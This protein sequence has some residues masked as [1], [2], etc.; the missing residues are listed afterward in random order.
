MNVLYGHMR[1]AET[2]IRKIKR[3]CAA[4]IDLGVISQA[5]KRLAKIK[6]RYAARIACTD[7]SIEVSNE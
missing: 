2:Q 4:R 3:R 7:L 1:V 6:R 5:L